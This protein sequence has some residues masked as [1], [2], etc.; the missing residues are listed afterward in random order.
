MAF[1]LMDRYL[2]FHTFSVRFDALALS[3]AGGTAFAQSLK[4]LN[5]LVLSAKPS[6]TY[7]FTTPTTG[8]KD[9][10][11]V[12]EG[13]IDFARQVGSRVYGPDKVLFADSEPV[14]GAGIWL[15]GDYFKYE[16]FTALTAFPAL[17][18]PVTLAN[19]PTPPR[20]GRLVRA[21]V[22]GNVGGVALVENVDYTV[23]YANRTITRLTAWISTTV[24]VTYTQLSI[25]NLAD[26]PVSIGD[27]PLLVNGVDPALI[28]GAFSASAAG[29]D[30]VIEGPTSPR[31]IGL[32]ERALIVS[33]H[34]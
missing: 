32:V 23:D 1:V 29:W 11:D 18:A 12:E 7:V 15:V 3:A 9:I 20:H 34:P 2:K 26:A 25:E 21:Y 14:V 6:H 33:A 28:T 22:A 16:Y 31:D 13:P 8:F 4:D 30:G 24:N 19:T 5:K 10:I 27:M 17:F